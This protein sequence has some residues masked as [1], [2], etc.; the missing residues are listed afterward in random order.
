MHTAASIAAISLAIFPSFIAGTTPPSYS[1][2]NTVWYDAFPGAAGSS[3]NTNNWNIITGYLGVNNELETYTSS[4]LNVQISGGSTVQLVPWRDSSA[5]YGWTSGRLESKYTFTPSASG[6]TMAEASIRFGG[7]AQV[8]KQGM[9]PA[10]W[11]L[12]DALRHG[13]GWPACGE[14]DIMEMVDGYLT[15]YGTVHCN[16]YPGGICNEPSGIG[17]STAVSDYSWHTWRIVVRIF[18]SSQTP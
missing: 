12:G 17:A 9:W 5:T 11:L 14:L 15:G 6:K 2:Y 18:L 16:V 4:N 8:N 7:N 3:P 1:G 13:T 10:F